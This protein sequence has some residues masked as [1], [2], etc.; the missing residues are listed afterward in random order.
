MPYFNAVFVFFDPPHQRLAAYKLPATQRNTRNGRAATD[1]TT[2][3]FSD[4][5]LR[6]MQELRNIGQTQ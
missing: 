4:V 3:N 2:D 5:R 1:K 6:A